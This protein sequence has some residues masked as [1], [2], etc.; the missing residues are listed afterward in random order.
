MRETIGVRGAKE[1]NLKNIDIEIP[2][3]QFVVVTGVSGSGKSSLAF[4]TIYAEGQRRF[5]ESLSAYS[6]RFVVQLKKPKVDF[7][8]GLSP[9]ISIEQ[10]SV[11]NNPRSTVGTMTDIYDYVR[12][13]FAT[14]GDA[15]CPF[16]TERVP[17][18]SA[19]QMTEHLLSLP[20]KTSIEICAP[21]L[22]PYGE[23]YPFLFGEIR[24]KG[25]RRMRI[26][27]ELVDL[28]DDLELDETREYCLEAVIDKFYLSKDLFKQIETSIQHGL[29]VG[30]GFL[31]FRILSDLPEETKRKFFANFACPNHQTTMGELLAYYFS[32]NEPDSA[33]NT[34]LGLG[35]YLNVHPDLLVPD[36]N[37]SVIGGCFVHEAFHYDKNS[38]GTRL[39]HSLSV[40]YGIDLDMPF[41][42]L[43]AKSVEL[44]FY[45]SKGERFPLL[46]PEGATKG[47]EHI[48]KPFR[49]DGIINDIER[50]YRHYRQQ[51]VAHSWMEEYL[52]K[53]MVERVCPDCKGTRLKKQR[54]CVTLQDRNI[55]ELSNFALSDLRDF[56]RDMPLSH[57]QWG[58]GE[59]V[60]DEIVSRLELLMG[61][62]MDYLSLG[63]KA[64]TLSGG[65]SQRIRLSTQIGSGLMGMLY[66]LDEPRIRA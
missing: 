52:K 44:L 37:R 20:P 33:C 62:G 46:I 15:K 19:P 2:R 7:V 27:D 14:I 24:N 9:V 21:V 50:R 51:K 31:R 64:A 43:S 1:N 10:K 13:L 25:Y 66:V 53:V 38:W 8:T 18:L 34:C 35:V 23:D 11:N 45:G 28:S 3:N 48:G 58:A 29:R 41:K 47:D 55:H 63:R 5:L 60:R 40:Q 22:K 39:M 54:L 26:D 36:K 30:D 17:V 42:D 16:C 32:F 12:I 61:I 49:F 56:L 59:Q 65:E 4:E 6:K 57:R